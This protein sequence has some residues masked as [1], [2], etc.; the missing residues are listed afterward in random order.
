KWVPQSLIR[1]LGIPKQ[2]NSFFRKVI[3]TRASLVGKA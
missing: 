2:Q 3:T 1:A